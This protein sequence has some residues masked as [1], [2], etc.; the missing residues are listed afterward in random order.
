MGLDVY[1]NR[2]WKAEIKRLLDAVDHMRRLQKDF[3]RTKRLDVLEQSKQ[4]EKKVDALLDR[5]RGGQMG[6]FDES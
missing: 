5:L 2:D 6:L 4:A 1:L 3:F